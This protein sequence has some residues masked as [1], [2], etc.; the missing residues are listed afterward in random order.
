MPKERDHYSILQVNRLAGADEIDASYQRLA[1]LYDP[2]VSR[3]PRAA[4]RWTQIKGAYDVLSD[5]RRRAEDDR[6]LARQSGALVGPEIPLP[7]FRSSRYSLTVAAIG[8]VLIPVGG[9]TV[10]SVRGSGCREW[11]VRQ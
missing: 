7:D 1:R 3:K 5:P 6:K 2:A 8:R 11:E 10:A 4:A 9:L